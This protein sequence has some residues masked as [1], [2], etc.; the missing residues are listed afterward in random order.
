MCI[1]D[2]IYPPPRRA[3]RA[4]ARSEW[5]TST[6]DDNTC[7]IKRPNA[8]ALTHCRDTMCACA[9]IEHRRALTH[10]R[11]FH[12]GNAPSRQ[13]LSILTQPKSPSRI[14]AY[15]AQSGCA[16]RERHVMRCLG[17]SGPRRAGPRRDLPCREPRRDLPWLL[18]PPLEGRLCG[19]L[20]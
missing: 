3:R 9:G 4:G 8:P 1:R 17:L 11:T 10:I 15:L 5:D 2:S 12:P 14:T 6:H 16:S 18:G 7:S 13:A 19:L 20:R